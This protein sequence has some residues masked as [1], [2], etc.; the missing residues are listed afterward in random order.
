MIGGRDCFEQPPQ[1]DHRWR[2][3]VGS[4]CVI[5]NEEGVL[6]EYFLLLLVLGFLGSNRCKFFNCSEGRK[7]GCWGMS[8]IHG[9]MEVV[10]EHGRRRVIDDEVVVR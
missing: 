8:F 7:L 4:V 2:W 3:W 5:V 6:V 1:T 9:W 10:W